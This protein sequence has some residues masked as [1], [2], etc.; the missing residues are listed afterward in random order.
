MGPSMCLSWLPGRMPTTESVDQVLLADGDVRTEFV[1]D[2]AG[3]DQLS[4]S[5]QED[6]LVRGAGSQR[7]LGTL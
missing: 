7:C 5:F 1:Q 2:P 3:L 4:L 6:R